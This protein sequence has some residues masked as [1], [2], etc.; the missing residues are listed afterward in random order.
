MYQMI[1]WVRAE[2][3]LNAKKILQE[4]YYKHWDAVGIQSAFHAAIVPKAWVHLTSLNKMEF[5]IVLHAIKKCILLCVVIV[6]NLLLIVVLLLLAKN[7]IQ[8]ASF[9]QL[10][11]KVSQMVPLSLI[12]I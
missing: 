9:V 12:H 1:I 11:L 5:L 4:K 2:I 6:I 8:I 3:V 10:V 7:G